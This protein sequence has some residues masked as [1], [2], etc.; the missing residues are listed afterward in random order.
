MLI[1]R[2]ALLAVFGGVLY[3]QLTQLDLRLQSRDVDFSAASAT[4]PL[5]SGTGLPSS[6]GQGELYYRL[7]ASAGMNVY[8]CTSPN[9]WTLEQGPPAASMA[10]QLGDFGVTATNTTTLSGSTE[11]ISASLSRPFTQ[12][13][14]SFARPLASATPLPSR[15]NR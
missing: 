4:K 1:F 5:K 14:A 3:G 8:G 13:P 9:S 2:I 7:D 15:G 11:A 12:R 6:C 10:S